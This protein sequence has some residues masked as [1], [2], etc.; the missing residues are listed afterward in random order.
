MPKNVL[1]NREHFSTSLSKET[2]QALKEHSQKTL[3]PISKIVDAA[4]TEYINKRTG[5]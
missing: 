5:D 4:I 3:I 1:K 2:V